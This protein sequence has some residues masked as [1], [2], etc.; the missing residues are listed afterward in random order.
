[1]K[2]VACLEPEPMFRP[3]CIVSYA[4]VTPIRF[5]GFGVLVPSQPWEKI[6]RHPDKLGEF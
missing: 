3:K 5:N 4:G 6:L 2:G 1:M